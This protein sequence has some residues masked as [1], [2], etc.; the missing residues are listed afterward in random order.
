M[1][2]E[3]KRKLALF[4]GAAT[5][6]CVSVVEALELISDGEGEVA[7]QTKSSMKR[8]C[9]AYEFLCAACKKMVARLNESVKSQGTLL[10]PGCHVVWNEGIV[11]WKLADPSE[12][13]Q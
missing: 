9:A 3:K 6:T 8:V 7:P 12:E 5:S 10:R 11:V 1:R 13:V 2:F 4:D